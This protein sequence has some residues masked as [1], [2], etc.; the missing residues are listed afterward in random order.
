PDY[1]ISGIAFSYVFSFVATAFLNI[2]IIRKK[3]GLQLEPLFFVRIS[4]AGLILIKMLNATAYLI[5]NNIILLI[6]LVLAHTIVYF[7]LLL[8][9]GDKYSRLILNQLFKANSSR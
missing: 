2:L 4:I 5:Q 1:Y 8:I 9:M 7:F 3:G 6:L